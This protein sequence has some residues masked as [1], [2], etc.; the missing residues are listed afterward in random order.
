[1][2]TDT[3]NPATAD[4]PWIWREPILPDEATDR[5]RELAAKYTRISWTMC[6]DAEDAHVARLVVGVQSW[7]VTATA[8]DTRDEASVHCWMLAKALEALVD[9]ELKLKGGA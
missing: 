6:E 8:C 1:M 3:F 4:D 5:Q 2:S 9:D 7:N